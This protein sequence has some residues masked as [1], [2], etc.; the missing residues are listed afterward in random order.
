[1]K[2]AGRCQGVSAFF[3]SC[4]VF[5]CLAGRK[6]ST[7][8]E[9]QR[10][11]PHAQRARLTGDAPDTSS[12]Q[13]LR[14]GRSWWP[15]VQCWC[16]GVSI[17]RKRRRLSSASISYPRA[18]SRSSSRSRMQPAA[19]VTWCRQI[20]VKVETVVW[21]H[22][23]P[24]QSQSILNPYGQPVITIA[25]Y[26]C[27]DEAVD[28]SARVHPEPHPRLKHGKPPQNHHNSPQLAELWTSRIVPERFPKRCRRLLRPDQKYSRMLEKSNGAC[29]AVCTSS[30]L[31]LESGLFLL[32]MASNFPQIG[33]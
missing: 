15:L 20:C 3:A 5:L 17:E 16:S 24:V 6:S 21:D 13:P 9:S 27:S 1:M 28:D 23:P 29:G 4:R 31:S 8:H 30:I 26:P 32:A 14:R 2:L 12:E 19:L 25:C 7:H 18:N 22:P 10:R 33:I 11:V